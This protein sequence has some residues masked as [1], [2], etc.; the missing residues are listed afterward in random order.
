MASRWTWGFQHQRGC[1]TGPIDTRNLTKPV[2]RLARFAGNGRLSVQ[3]C[4]GSTDDGSDLRKDPRMTV[5]ATQETIRLVI[6][7]ETLGFRVK[8]QFPVRSPRDVAQMDQA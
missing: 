6:I 5:I 3:C 4:P 2:G 7:S 8:L 1:R